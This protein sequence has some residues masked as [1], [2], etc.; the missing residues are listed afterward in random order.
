MCAEVN[1]E[2]VEETLGTLFHNNNNNNS[3]NYE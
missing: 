2:K 3:E 1:E